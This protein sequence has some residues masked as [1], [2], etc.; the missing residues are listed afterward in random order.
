[1]ERIHDDHVARSARESHELCMEPLA[2][3]QWAFSAEGLPQLV[4]LA[5]GD[6]SHQNRFHWAN[7][8]LTKQH[9]P[10][11]C[12]FRVLEEPMTNLAGIDDLR[13]FLA[14]CPKDT[15]LYKKVTGWPG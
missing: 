1:M 8:I 13:T 7:M 5:Y 4:T 3:A 12:K 14:V 2:L 11:R 15:L 10:A 6:F 9:L